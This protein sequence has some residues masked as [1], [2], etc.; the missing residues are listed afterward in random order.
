[1]NLKRI[2]QL[3]LF[4]FI[5]AFGTISLIPQKIEPAFWLVIFVFCAIVIA[6]AAPGKYFLHGFVLSLFNS[7]W[8]TAVH[9][10]AYPAYA[11]KHADVVDM[12]NKIST[13]FATHPR[14]AMV[15]MAPA[16]GIV[17]GL[18]QGLFAFIASKVVAKKTA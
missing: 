16:F 11:A 13:Y 9:I 2:L 4:G 10:W 6:K 17:F 1:M 5:M 3:S 14:I 7:V 8:I 15:L 12:S 18:F